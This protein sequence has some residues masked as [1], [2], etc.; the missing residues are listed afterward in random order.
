[1]HYG[2]Y[3]LATCLCITTLTA[4][5]TRK[6]SYEN[7]PQTQSGQQTLKMFTPID[8]QATI[9]I[10]SYEAEA[11]ARK[12][13]AQRQNLGKWT[14]MQFAITQS[15]D[16]ASKKKPS[17][18]A[19]QRGSLTITYGKLAASLAHLKNLLPKLDKQPELLAKE[20]TWYR[21]APDFGFTGY[22]EPSL[23]ASRKK[24]VAYPYPLYKLP[25][26]IRKGVPYYTRNKIDRGGALAGKN[27]EL[28]WVSSEVDAFFLHIQGS[29]RLV[30]EDGTTSHALYAGKNNRAYRA[31]GGIMRDKGMLAAD[32]ISMESIRAVLAKMS[33]AERSKLLDENPSYIFFREASSG[34]VG[35]MGRPLTPWVS[36]ATDRNV[37]PHGSLTFVAVPLPDKQ[38]NFTQPFFALTLPQ[39]TGGAIRGNRIDLFGG[40]SADGSHMAGHLDTKGAV[41][42]LIK[43]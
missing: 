22:Y 6:G 38:G 25:P 5:S 15:L 28:A 32:N 26:D 37:L 39:D 18:I 33:Y 16:F 36:L 23:K 11:L 42:I 2:V 12:L 31:L 30:F 17:D 7:Q 4:C 20:F 29:G 1:M 40:A 10:S 43:K 9:P 21:I 14:N 3:L 8:R 24:S 19:I 13:N 34:P 41:Y 27:L 35:A